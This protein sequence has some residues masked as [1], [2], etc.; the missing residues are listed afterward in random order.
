MKHTPGPWEMTRKAEYHSIVTHTDQSGRMHVVADVHD[1]G[2]DALLIAAAPK[3]FNA[4]VSAIKLLERDMPKEGITS[5]MVKQ[6]KDII[7]KA[8]GGEI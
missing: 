6:F 1:N 3:L 4:L 8:K 5:L 7:A 2:A